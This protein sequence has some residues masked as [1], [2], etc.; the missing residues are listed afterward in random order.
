MLSGQLSVQ[1]P[2]P[3]APDTVTVALEELS[4]GFISQVESGAQGVALL[5]MLA[6]LVKS[7]PADVPVTTE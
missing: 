4:P 1:V 5:E 6:T 7:V 2:V 3:P